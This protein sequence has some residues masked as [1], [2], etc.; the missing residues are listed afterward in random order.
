L[1]RPKN[2]KLSDLERISIKDKALIDTAMELTIPPLAERIKFFSPIKRKLFDVIYLI[3]YDIENDKVRKEIAEYLIKIG[4]KRIQLS[5]YMNKSNKKKY[6]NLKTT[7]TEIQALYENSD[8][9]LLVPLGENTMEKI[10][11]I[12]KEINVETLI[13]PPSTLFI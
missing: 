2:I 10:S 11:I 9:I 6:H 13:A 1:G 12:G 5:V 7:L 8:S 4:C 3:M